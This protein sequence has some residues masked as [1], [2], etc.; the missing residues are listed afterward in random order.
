VFQV[1]I[2]ETRV[3][4]FDKRW[5]KKLLNKPIEELPSNQELRELFTNKKTKEPDPKLVKG[6]L[7]ALKTITDRRRLS[8]KQAA[9]R[10]DEQYEVNLLTLLNTLGDSTDKAEGKQVLSN[11]VGLGY[12][13]TLIDTLISQL[14]AA[15]NA[16]LKLEE[17]KPLWVTD[18][19]QD[20]L[21]LTD[22]TNVMIA[23]IEKVTG[24]E[25]TDGETPKQAAEEEE[26][27]AAD[28]PKR[29]PGPSRG[30]VERPDAVNLFAAEDNAEQAEKRSDAIVQE[31]DNEVV[32]E[33]AKVDALADD[34]DIKEAEEDSL[35]EFNEPEE[36]PAAP[37]PV[38]KDQE[39]APVES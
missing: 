11:M 34:G 22:F 4:D 5:V 31:T 3:G 12:D 7:E 29:E 6:F 1:Y 20:M 10:L 17:I 8:I 14:D 19:K 21:G 9:L 16:R 38:A 2:D 25:A 35:E 24:H 32:E 13:K 26:V 30:L 23:Q 15:L 39:A 36:K 37:V 33:A 27:E 28:D 18:G